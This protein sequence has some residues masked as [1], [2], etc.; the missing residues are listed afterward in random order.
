[1]KNNMFNDQAAKKR[2]TT[3]AI[4]A[5]FLLVWAVGIFGNLFVCADNTADIHHNLS[6]MRK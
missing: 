4:A 5:L 2:R 3:E 6:E 1:M